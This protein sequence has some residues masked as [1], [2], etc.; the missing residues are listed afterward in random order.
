[1][2]RANT[3]Q[4]ESG[5]FINNNCNCCGEQAKYCLFY[6]PTV[7]NG[8]AELLVSL[9]KK[10]KKYHKKYKEY[11]KE[12]NDN[13]EKILATYKNDLEIEIK[14]AIKLLEKNNYTIIKK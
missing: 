14:E 10:H 3:K 5:N 12:Y 4:W 9:C 8:D 11:Y 7:F 1:M 6:Y 13:L 2:A